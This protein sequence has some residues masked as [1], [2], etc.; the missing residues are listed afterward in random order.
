MTA[1]AVFV[2]QFAELARFLDIAS[3]ADAGCGDFSWM[4]Q[5][6]G[7]F[8][9][10]FGLDRNKALI[11]DLDE[12]HGNRRGHF[13]AARDVSKSPLPTVDAILCRNLFGENDVEAVS[14][15]L[16]QVKASGSRYLMANTTPGAPAPFDLCAAPFNLPLPLMQFQEQPGFG[17]LLGVWQ[18]PKPR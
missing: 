7:Q 16:A 8:T 11:A 10:Y 17:K 18:I 14:A 5:V 1:P 13:F 4:E 12:R 3:L 15:I 2:T 6:S 9:L